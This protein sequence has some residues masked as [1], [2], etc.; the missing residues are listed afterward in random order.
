MQYHL[1]TWPEVDELRKNNKTLLIL[2]LGTVEQHGYHLPLGTD[3]I[4]L[5]S[6]LQIAI[7]K[8]KQNRYILV[9]PILPYGFSHHHVAFPGTLS[10]SAGL[11]ENVLL[12]LGQQLLSQGFRKLLLISWHG[13]HTSIMH[14][15][16]YELKKAFYDKH[17]FYISIIDF[18]FNKIKE[19]ISEPVYHADDLE[20]SIML[21]LGQRVL[22]DKAIK[23][24]IAEVLDEYTYLDFKK[25]S[26]VK[27]PVNIA[28]FSK[29]DVI[30]DPTSSSIEKGKLLIEIITDELAKILDKI[31]KI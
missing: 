31:V 29:S 6:V 10:L 8:S 18:A 12:T 14:D 17:I 5:E 27:I 9:L 7:E 1:L 23:D 25:S 11:L 4:I 22:M 15:V 19:L 28:E 2:P 26:R 16:S 20:T 3:T 30:D 21:A 13:G 24:G